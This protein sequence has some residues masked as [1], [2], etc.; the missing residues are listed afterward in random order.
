LENKLLSTQPDHQNLTYKNFNTKHVMRWCLIIEEFGQTIQYIEGPKNIVAN[1]LSH[2]DILPD[3]ESL[4]MADCHGLDDD[5]QS[6]D[7]IPLTYSL[8]DCEQQKDAILLAQAQKAQHY[9]LKKFHGG[10]NA[11]HKLICFK[12][13]IVIPTTLQKHSMQCYHYLLCHPGINR[14]EETIGQH[15]LA[16]NERSNN[17]GHLYMWHLSNSKETK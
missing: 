17:N 15:L 13:K 5:D 11:I 8:I 12:D 4:D 14:N 16:K 10:S 1:T 3:E 6:S 7:S 2:L 9:S